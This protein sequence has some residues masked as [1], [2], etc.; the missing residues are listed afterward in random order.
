[1]ILSI[2]TTLY[3]S[4]SYID[5]FYDRISKTAQQITDDYEIIFVDDGSP[6]DSLQKAIALHHKDD[7]VKVIELSRNFQHHKAIVTGMQYAKGDYIFYIDIDL[8]EDPEILGDFWKIIDQDIAID[9]VYGV[10]ESR[11][12]GLFEKISGAL[13][14]KMYN[15]ISNI[16]MPK[17]LVSARLFSQKTNQAV[18]SYKER[19]L[20]LACIW[21]DIGF[22]QY[23]VTVNKKSTSKTSYS[24]KRK[25]L[26][27]LNG[28]L[29]FTNKPLL[30]IFNIGFFITIISFLYILKLLIDKFYFDI[31]V[32]GWTGIIVSIWFFGGLIIF[33]MGIIG[34]Y[35]AKIFIETKERPYSI[36]RKIYKTKE[37]K[38]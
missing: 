32:D 7:K 19:E 26:L 10:Q 16:K 12:G 27:L 36:I 14:Y 4:S 34:L 5:E 2:V 28:I 17:N 13:F 6:D 21:H 23:E 15:L 20:C 25:L 1:M 31:I 29:S 30:F 9:V 24:L 33:F 37:K 35:I 8:E 22:N 18:L 38:E 3:Y 11:K